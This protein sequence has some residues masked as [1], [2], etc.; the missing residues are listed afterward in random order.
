MKIAIAQLN[1]TVGDVAGNTAKIAEFAERARAM[2]AGLLLTPELSISGYPPEDLLLREDFC[3]ACQRAVD[4]LASRLRGIRAVVGHPQ[5]AAG[6]CFNAASVIGDGQP[7][8]TYHK[9][10]LPNY[11][12]F[13]EERYF[14]PGSGSCV[15][16]VGGLRAGINIC[17]DVWGEE[18]MYTAH[19]L[20]V[21]AAHSSVWVARAPQAAR[22]AGAQVLLVL[23]ASPFHLDKQRTRHEIVRAR[24][25]ET[26]MPVVFCNMVGGQDELVF[27]GQSFVVDVG[28]N[29]KLQM[30]SF[31]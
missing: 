1:C 22:D 12:V 21:C 7:T 11:T 5:R 28:G 27:D 23:N 19:A 20:H 30:P 10:D 3:R 4:E 29:V 15:V 8:A 9:R 6:R 17:E 18:G 14:E 25:R 16:E 26:G 31:R 24:A 2:G 13:D